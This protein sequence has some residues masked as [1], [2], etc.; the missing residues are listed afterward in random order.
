MLR[1]M[2]E[3][4]RHRW[5]PVI[6]LLTLAGLASCTTERDGA[7][8]LTGP[9][10]TGG[11]ETRG[12]GDTGSGSGDGDSGDGDSGADSDGSSGSGSG[13]ETSGG[14][15]LRLDVGEGSGGGIGESGGTIGCENIAAL[16]V[17][18]ISGSMKEERDDL[19][20][21]FPNFVSV[22]DA[23]VGDPDSG[24]TGYR[25]GVTNSSIEDNASGESDLAL[26]GSLYAGGTFVSLFGG[27][28]ETFSPAWID[29]PG[30]T[31]SEDF[32]CLADYP[33]AEG[34]LDPGAERP[35]DA[36]EYFVDKHAAGGPNDGFYDRA[37]SLLVIV[38]LTDE[39]DTRPDST[40]TPAETKAKLDAFTGGEDRYVVVTIAGPESGQCNSEFGEATAAPILHEFTN[41]VDNGL[42]GD[43]CQGDLSSALA[44]ALALIQTSCDELPP[45]G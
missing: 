18:D 25:L 30:A 12:P 39:D 14:G 41:S 32:T 45:V 6:A 43:I 3:E 9:D 38:T 7:G 27:C 17:V 2:V 33:I 37:N 31:V 28:E 13:E 11:F 34:G 42:M 19:A 44:D 15:G 29:G 20:A 21:N 16:F 8:N 10:D 24:A 35:L 26:D 36:I 40:T 4:T 1:L 22:L 5:R 23:Y